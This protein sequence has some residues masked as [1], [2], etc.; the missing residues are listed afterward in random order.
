[1][2]SS[3][4]DSIYPIVSAASVVAKVTRD[5]N[6]E[7]YRES[8]AIL[9]GQ[10]L[11]SGYPS[12]P[13]TSKWLNGHVDQVFGWHFGLIRFSWQ[14]AKDSLVKNNAADVIYE[15]ECIKDGGYGDVDDLFKK[16]QSAVEFYGVSAEM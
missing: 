13:N 4:L 11:G 3:D 6:L 7:F 9:Q 2:C 1:M 12:D 10:N 15:L 5:M 16:E 8:M 14:T